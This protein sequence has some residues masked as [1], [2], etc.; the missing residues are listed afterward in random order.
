M[1]EIDRADVLAVLRPIWFDKTETATRVGGRLEKVLDC[2]AVNEYRTGEN[3]ARWR[4]HLEVVL[5]KPAKIMQR[6]HHPA[7]PYKDVPAAIQKIISTG[8]LARWVLL[9]CVLTAARTA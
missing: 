7:V 9:L 3:P 6:R 8:G 2:A 5:P 1:G 4:G